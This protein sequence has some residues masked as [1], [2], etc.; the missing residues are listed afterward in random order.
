MPAPK[1]T[2]R[3][4]ACEPARGSRLAD[5]SQTA[6]S[7]RAAHDDGASRIFSAG[8]QDAF[9]RAADL[10]RSSLASTALELS[11]LCQQIK[12]GQEIDCGRTLNREVTGCLAAAANANVM[13]WSDLVQHVRNGLAQ[14]DRKP[15]PA[16]DAHPGDIGAQEGP[17]FKPD[18][19]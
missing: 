1:E 12:P 17:P 18:R 14:L 4:Q 2:R 16:T 3:A 13:I 5:A 11:A 19:P 9:M 15:Q 7:E 6:P 10:Q 8:V